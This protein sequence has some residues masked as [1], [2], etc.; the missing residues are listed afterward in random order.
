L[1]IVAA[2][3]LLVV[4]ASAPRLV[5]PPVASAA[6]CSPL[7]HAPGN[8][9]RTIVSGGITRTY[10]L[11]IPPGYDGVTPMP[12]VLDYHGRG[13]NIAQQIF[14]ADLYARADAQGFLVAT[15]QG[16]STTNSPPNHWNITQVPTNLGEA[17]DVLFSSQMIDDVAAQVCV[18]VARVYSTGMSNGGQM[19]VRLGCS[20]SSRIAAI[21]PVAGVYYPPLLSGQNETCPDTRPMP[22]MAFHGTD[23]DTIPFDGGAGTQGLIFRD[24]DDVVMPAWASRN[25]CDP[26]PSTSLAAPGVN[27][28]EYGNCD[29]GATAALYAVFDYDGDGPATTGGGH[30]WP[31]SP[32]MPAGHTNAIEATD[33][34]L[35]FFAQFTL[36]CAA[37]D[38]DCDTISDAA[39]NCAAAYNP[40][41]HNRDGLAL[42][43]PGKPFDD[44]SQPHS[45]TVG[46]ACDPDDDNDGRSDADELGGIGCGGAITD[47][48]DADSDGDNFLDGAE[49]ALGANPA[50]GGPGF[51]SRPTLAQ[52]GA[53]TDADGDGVILQREFCFYNTDPNNANTDGD[54]C[55]DGR[56]V[57][58]V[59]A[60]NSV[61]VLDLLA[62]ALEAG[63]YA[64]PGPVVKVNF[65][66]T[67]NGSI[68]VLD[69][70]FV[71]GR[72]G[73]CP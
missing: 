2:A 16:R 71:A 53:A 44:V 12:L 38:A 1:V 39:D 66:A 56:E 24:I 5:S 58:S 62:I 18:D 33:L 64:L 42:D 49:C 69:L 28:I 4:A 63:T 29:D 31:G 14:V 45:D 22:I 47:P 67:K 50:A 73:N 34:M 32:Y 40:G 25:G 46:D 26:M 37:G 21:A 9:A 35:A 60:N 52:C 36:P 41:Q 7:P 43:L 30:I 11:H 10:E 51:A 19:S 72:A 13:S 68:D 59:N 54:A 57:A 15:P 55:T 70:A 48:F 3:V 65:D 6:V 20:L 27:L 17:D 23:D 61:D 8:V